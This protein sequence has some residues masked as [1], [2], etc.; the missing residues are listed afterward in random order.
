[1]L[2]WLC[3]EYICVCRLL[4]WL[5][6]WQFDDEMVVVVVVGCVVG[7]VIMCIGDGFD[8]CQVEFVVIVLV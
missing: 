3:W 7:M 2:I 5:L 8:Y 1:M 4:V 6:V